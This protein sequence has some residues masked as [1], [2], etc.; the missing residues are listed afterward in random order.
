MVAT[1]E[2][3]KIINLCK[4]KC[5]KDKLL[6]KRRCKLQNKQKKFKFRKNWETVFREKSI[7]INKKRCKDR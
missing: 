6:N 4:P 5:I 3:N 2:S 1:Y 7:K